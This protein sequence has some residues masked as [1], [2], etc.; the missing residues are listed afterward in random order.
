MKMWVEKLRSVIE[1][2]S[3]VE[4]HHT[5]FEGWLHHAEN[6]D[7]SQPGHWTKRYFSL[8][9]GRL[10]LF[11]MRFQGRIVLRHDTESHICDQIRHTISR[12]R[13]Y[14]EPLHSRSLFSFRFIVST[15]NHAFRFA[16][17][18]QEEMLDWCEAIKNARKR[19]ESQSNMDISR[20]VSTMYSPFEGLLNPRPPSYQSLSS[21]K[22]RNVSAPVGQVSVVFTDI[23]SSTTIWSQVPDAMNRALEIHDSLMRHHLQLCRGYEVKTEGDAFMVAFFTAN[24][25]A[26]WCLDVQKALLYCQWSPEILALDACKTELDANG[27]IVFSGLRVRMGIHTSNTVSSRVNPVTG[28]MDYFGAAI[29]ESA[30]VSDSANGG[31]VVCTETV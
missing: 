29:N 23:Q 19:A 31:Q 30:R 28:R 10:W 7:E 26:R 4:A 27:K 6:R 25:A 17:D 5:Q 16:A 3:M 2:P 13:V 9:G 18:T 22:A 20:S 21:A 11:D 8:D 24:D 15:I 14:H 1:S 12:D